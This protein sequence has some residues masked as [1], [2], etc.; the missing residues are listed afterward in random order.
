MTRRQPA[1]TLIGTSYGFAVL[2]LRRRLVTFKIHRRYLTAFQHL[3]LKKKCRR[4][5]F[6]LVTVNPRLPYQLL[7]HHSF[8]HVPNAT[9]VAM[10]GALCRYNHAEQDAIYLWH[11]VVWC[12]PRF[13]RLKSLTPLLTF[14]PHSGT[15]ISCFIK[16]HTTVKA[17]T[18]F[19]HPQPHP[20][21]L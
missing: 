1:R 4:N 11:M 2:Q 5:N 13:V 19:V 21:P 6:Q 15:E 9:T 7:R 17:L 10:P 16:S 3:D 8:Y 18:L 12:Y 20:L 14:P